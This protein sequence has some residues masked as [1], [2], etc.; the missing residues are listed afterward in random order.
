MDKEL[1]TLMI[2][3]LANSVM[4]N[5]LCEV[6]YMQIVKE[7]EQQEKYEKVCKAVELACQDGSRFTVLSNGIESL[8]EFYEREK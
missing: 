5:K 6:K 2:M 3:C 4:E 7:L 8:M 1:R